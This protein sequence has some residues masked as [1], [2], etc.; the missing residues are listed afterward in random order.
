MTRSRYLIPVLLL[1]SFSQLALACGDSLYRAGKGVA[2]RTYTAPL[3]GNLLVVGNSER[4]SE[5]VAALQ[6]SGHDVRHAPDAV[7]MRA[8]I[9][10][11]KF[12]VVLAPETDRESV[13]AS[14]DVARYVPVVEK[15]SVKHYL[16]AIH[17]ILKKS[18]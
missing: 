6:E 11:A 3:P 7:S 10:T 12:D 4:V 5:L 17:K 18:A 15:Q 16:K 8:A 9:E 13:A 1:L 2:Y 14:V